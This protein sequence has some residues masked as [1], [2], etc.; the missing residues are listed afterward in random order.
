MYKKI[1][2]RIIK[3]TK[4][5]MVTCSSRV[6]RAKLEDKHGE[7]YLVSWASSPAVF[8]PTVRI[9]SRNPS[10]FDNAWNKC[11]A[12]DEVWLYHSTD[13]DFNF[14]EPLA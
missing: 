1:K 9:L 8:G 14:F 10:E 13:N 11:E 5:D 4:D 2:A 6:I 3:I 12:G 7:T